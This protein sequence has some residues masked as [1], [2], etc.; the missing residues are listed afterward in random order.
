M[1]KNFNDMF[2]DIKKWVGS[3]KDE[4]CDERRKPKPCSNNI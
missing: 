1:K 3:C 2:K 4:M